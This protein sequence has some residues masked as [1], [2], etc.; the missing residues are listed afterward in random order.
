MNTPAITSPLGDAP[1][2]ELARRVAAGEP[3]AFE[4]LMR[5]H[6]RKL[7]RTARAILRDDA[8]AEDALQDAYIQALRA[9]GGFRGEAKLSTWL[10]KVVANEALMRRRKRVRRAEIVPLQ[11]GTTESELNE[12]PDGNMDEQPERSAQR[13][14]MRRLLEAQIDSLPDDFRAVFVLRAVEEMSVEE[15]AEALGI[16]QA[17]V[18]TRLFR[19][20]SLLREALAA[21]I[22]LACEEAFSFAGDRCDRI[23]AKVMERMR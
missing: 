3:A 9:I 14:E 13:S 12:I 11:P 23:V 21:K 22:D 19:A 2:N 6:N 7:F 4:A 16:P 15:T 5:R 10:A 18:R 17:T 20:R 1:D 8:E